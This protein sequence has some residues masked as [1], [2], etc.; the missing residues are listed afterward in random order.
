MAGIVAD[1]NN[2]VIE[3]ES[4]ERGQRKLDNQGKGA[5]GEKGPST[6]LKGQLSVLSTMPTQLRSVPDY[7]QSGLDLFW[8]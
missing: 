5:G 2:A 3:S 7:A 8:S 1:Q 6:N 4:G